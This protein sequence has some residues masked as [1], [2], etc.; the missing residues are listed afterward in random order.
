MCLLSGAGW[1]AEGDRQGAVVVLTLILAPPARAYYLAL[2]TAQIHD[3]RLFTALILPSDQDRLR[4]AGSRSS[5]MQ[6]VAVLGEM[7][8]VPGDSECHKP[9]AQEVLLC[10]AVHVLCVLVRRQRASPWRLQA[11]NR[12]RSRLS[13]AVSR[14]GD[15]LAHTAHNNNG[16]PGESK[17][18]A[19][20]LDGVAVRVCTISD[21]LGEQAC[22]LCTAV[23][24]V[25]P[26]CALLPM[27]AQSEYLV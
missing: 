26:V 6:Y 12:R 16:R 3:P 25:S 23:C 10:S 1:G 19:S 17:L 5:T 24:Q 22:A 27:I 7:D 14:S 21:T 9:T 15:A 11:V 2:Q 13:R 20:G 8:Q 18:F 4:T